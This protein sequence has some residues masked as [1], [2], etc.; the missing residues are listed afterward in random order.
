[1]DRFVLP[2]AHDAGLFPGKGLVLDLGC[3]SGRDTVYMAQRLPPGTRI[4]GVDNHSYAL[5]RGARLAERWLEDTSSGEVVGGSGG[6]GG[7]E[8]GATRSQQETQTGCL[9]GVRSRAVGRS[10]TD[11]N[12]GATQGKPPEV[13][14]RAC[15]WSLAD[16]RKEGSLDGMRASIV[17][18][19]R[20]KCER[21][22]PLLRD[23]V[24]EHVGHTLALCLVGFS[25]SGPH[26]G[27]KIYR[28]IYKPDCAGGGEKLGVPGLEL[29]LCPGFAFC[30]VLCRA[31]IISLVAMH[32]SFPVYGKP[33]VHAHVLS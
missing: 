17:H 10:D 22:L 29:K 8:E 24:R 26:T 12:E 2:S 23:H 33:K 9:G 13:R 19:H 16:L 31:R 32:F 5:E 6:G 1:M 4:V 28:G 27:D 30:R 11:G 18:G 7:R 3:G 21:L 25:M 15:E 20:F 14:Q